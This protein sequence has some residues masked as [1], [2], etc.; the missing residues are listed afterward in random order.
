MDTLIAIVIVV[1][2]ATLIIKRVK[3]ELYNSIKDKLT[4]WI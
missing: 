2:I 3:P 1:T 4:K